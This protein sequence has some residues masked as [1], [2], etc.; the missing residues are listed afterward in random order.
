MKKQNIL[1]IIRDMFAGNIK[2]VGIVLIVGILLSYAF[3]YSSYLFGVIEKP[4]GLN[5]LF[6]ILLG[7]F[8][9]VSFAL[10]LK[11]KYPKNN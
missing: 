10:W 7:Q 2:D 3:F 1:T 11:N 8:I 4:P 5:N 9:L 6:S